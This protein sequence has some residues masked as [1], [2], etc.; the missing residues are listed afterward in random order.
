MFTGRRSGW[1][2]DDACAVCVWRKLAVVCVCA[3]TAATN[4]SGAILAGDRLASKQ[5][6]QDWTLHKV[7]KTQSIL[8]KNK[9]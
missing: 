1:R 4:S 3:W 5:Q 8:V 7:I 9:R 6:Q 2:G